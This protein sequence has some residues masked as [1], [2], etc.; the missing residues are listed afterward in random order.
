MTR[1][2]VGLLVLALASTPNWADPGPDQK[3]IES[4]KK[5]VA[6][7]VEKQRRIV[8]ETYDARRLARLRQ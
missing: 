5:R 6:G 4:I 1:G 2:I 7:S 8:V 3:H